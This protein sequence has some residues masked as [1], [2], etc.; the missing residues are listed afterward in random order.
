MNDTSSPWRG[1]RVLVTGCTGFLGS[2]VVRELLARGAEVVGLVRDRAADAEF[3]RHRLT[4]KVHVV[5]GRTEDLFRVHS[6]LAV[7]EARAVFHLA[8]DTD[9]GTATVLDAA[10]RYDSRVSVVVARPDGV[11]FEPPAG[12]PVGV[13][14]FGEIFGGGDRK[15]FRAVP[16]TA[17]GLLTGDRA[18]LAFE[19]PARDFVFVG[20]A[21]RAC[22]SVGEG[23]L[24]APGPRAEEH[25]F[26]SGWVCTD[27]EIAAAVKDVFAGRAV[28]SPPPPVNPFGWNPAAG[29]SDA[30]ADTIAWY[31]EFLRTRFFGTRP[32]GPPQRAAA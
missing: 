11:A 29:L 19:G 21:A 12:Q 5:H 28:P 7:H 8:G 15:T 27:R 1:R 4:G 10:R 17:V 30:L 6:A 31:R 24:A 26:R 20:D 9:R 22:V 3:T 23:L 25:A 2:A 13:A 16:A 32:L 18:A 14:R